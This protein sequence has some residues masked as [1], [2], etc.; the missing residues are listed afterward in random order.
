MFLA[1]RI[2]LLDNACSTNGGS[3]VRIR[4]VK[5]AGSSAARCK[6]NPVTSGT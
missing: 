4:S 5:A 3:T 6:K 2:R 1:K